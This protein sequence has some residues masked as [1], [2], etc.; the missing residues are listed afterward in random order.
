MES[1]ANFRPQKFAVVGAGPVGC[2]VAAFLAKSG[3]EVTLIYSLNFQNY[4]MYSSL[5]Q[6]N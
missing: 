3:Y 4:R 2:I 5:I 1:Q 6:T